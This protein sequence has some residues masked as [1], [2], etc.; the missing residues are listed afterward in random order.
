MRARFL[1]AAFSLLPLFACSG[2]AG[3]GM[4]PE[5]GQRASAQNGALALPGS[6]K[7]CTGTIQL[8]SV[9][10]PVV[11]NL[12]DG[13]LDNALAL[14]GVIPGLHPADLR[15]AYG[16]P[17]TGGAGSTIA[18][19]DG[20]DDPNAESDLAVYRRTFGLPACTTANG[21]FRKANE[22]GATNGTGLPAAS[23]EWSE[24]IAIDL[25][26]VS[27]ICPQC[28]VLLVET[29]STNISDFG[30]AVDTAVRLG[31]TEVSN[32][33]YTAEYAG[34]LADD[35]HYDHPGIPITASAG[36]GGYGVMFPASSQY[37][38]SVGGTSLTRALGTARGWTETV[39]DGTGSG[40]SAYV[41]KPAWQKDGG[42]TNRTV[43]DV[44][45]DGDPLTGVSG[46][47]TYAPV[48][49]RGWAVYGGTSVGA[50]VVAAIY[51]LAGNGSS[52]EGA[53]YV[54]AHAQSLHPVTTGSNGT[55]SPSYLC[56]AGPGYNGPG[57]LGTPNGTTAF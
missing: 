48:G 8:G 49:E 2:G 19:V 11:I 55:C 21:C 14:V 23:E 9:Q 40:C 24:E 15:S 10:C 31:A 43:A 17:S 50:P 6:G 51:A 57:G 47:N 29:N 27:A 34:V 5:A 39:W 20:G 1:A 33:Y 3:G 38:T 41:S 22:S 36:D 52:I 28:H 26:M 25:D 7:V 13:F 18:V 46:Y 35:V 45:V 54:Y 56:T 30:T 37:V 4:L 16:L 32:S 42:C 53:A 12:V 44:S